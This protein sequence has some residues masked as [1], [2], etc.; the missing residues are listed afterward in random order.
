MGFLLLFSPQ[1]SSNVV[2]PGYGGVGIFE[3]PA[4]AS[5]EAGVRARIRA[6]HTTEAID[7]LTRVINRFPDAAQLRVFQ[8]ELALQDGD[9]DAAIAALLMAERLGSTNL[10]QILSEPQ[11]AMIADDPR[12]SMLSINTQPETVNSRPRPVRGSDAVVT[13]ENSGWNAGLGRVVSRFT[14]PPATATRS[15]DVNAPDGA[16][17]HLRH[18]IASGKAAGNSGDLYD[19]RD[20]GH[21][22]LEHMAWTK[23]SRV[24]YDEEARAAGIHYGLN[25]GIL[26]DSPTFGNSSTALTGRLWR[27]QPRFAMTAPGQPRRLWDLYA[28][29]HL[30]VFPEHR[31]HD[32]VGEGG[33]GDVIPANTPYML[34]SQGSSGSDKPLLR[35]VQ[36]ILAAFKPEVKARLTEERLI[37]PMIQQVFRRGLHGVGE[38]GYLTPRAHATAFRSEDIDLGAM[39]AFA[40]S[41]EADVIPPMVKIAMTRESS[42]ELSVFGDGLSEVLF[43][44]PGAIARVWRAP[45]AEREYELSAGATDPNGRPVTYRWVLMRGDPERITIEPLDES[46]R[47]ARV[48]IGWDDPRPV[49]GTPELSSSRI[50]IAVFADNG[51]HLSAPAYFS[52]LLPAHQLRR[53]DTQ[54]RP[55]KIAYAP[56]GERPYADPLIWP[57][58]RWEDHFRYDPDGRLLGW[59]RSGR[60]YARKFTAYGHEVVEQDPLG[61]ALLA[62]QVRYPIEVVRAGDLR[63]REMPTD[64]RFRYIYED[65]DDLVGRPVPAAALEGA[66]IIGKN[67]SAPRATREKP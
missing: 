11:F 53:Y 39:I 18:L 26:F 54:G 34:I 13:G 36:A 25:T 37:A 27:S 15:L 49:E 4:L 6:G 21:S 43:D 30:Y 35:A 42:N 29:N 57:T 23:L 9:T 45:G 66:E 62:R 10:P 59:I 12:L 2:V 47:R 8:A 51:A 7:A 64:R 46:G 63:V 56:S 38:R 61:R 1:A 65:S 67:E 14:F 44:T 60:G 5:A 32:P 17:A 28:N 19:N 40:Q 33:H 31:D 58:R 50:D 48:R 41:L 52:V 20:D 16:F 22:S 55:V 24:S 3:M